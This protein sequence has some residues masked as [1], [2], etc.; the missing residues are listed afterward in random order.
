MNIPLS[1]FMA[2]TSS[3]EFLEKNRDLSQLLA[4]SFDDVWQETINSDLFVRTA[5]F[6]AILAALALAI[7]AYQ[8]LEY[9]Y[10][11]RGY[12]DWSSIII[13]VFL[14]ILLAKPVNKPIFLGEVLLAFRD[15]GNGIS[16]ELLNLLSK[17]LTTSKAADIG[18]VK[19]MMELIASDAVQTCAAIG[20]QDLRNDCFVDAE[21]Q[22][23]QIVNQYKDPNPV[24]ENWA[25]KLG[26]ELSQ[27]IQN[28]M[29]SSYANSRWFGR[30]FSGFGLSF[31]SANSFAVPILFLS[32]GYAFYWVLELIAILTALTSPI[33]LGISLY[34]IGHQPFLLSLS[35]FWGVWL[36]KF[37]YSLV[38][39]FTGLLMSLTPSSSTLLFPLIAGIFGP[40]IAFIMGAG[41]GLALFSLFTGA[42][43]LAL[44]RR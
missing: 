12:L 4:N 44:S 43:V 21:Q 16:T 3:Q 34:S 11:Q 42:G 40:I 8:W 17:D 29:G 28:A 10:G 1:L 19:T 18:A 33:F 2:Q 9:Q 38:I 14:V 37:C 7:F 35:L 15:M 41:G 26:R 6:G 13:P 36:A 20:E 23:L 39:G 31:Q 30:L 25:T 32:I 5:F 22:I 27:K 24:K